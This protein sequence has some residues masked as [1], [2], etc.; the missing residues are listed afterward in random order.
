[1]TLWRAGRKDLKVTAIYSGATKAPIA[2][3][4]IVG[5]LRIAAPDNDPVEIPLAATQEVARLGPFGRMAEAT[6]YLLWGK[7]R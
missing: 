5:M 1:V 7:K 6:G 3:G 2:N 4:Q